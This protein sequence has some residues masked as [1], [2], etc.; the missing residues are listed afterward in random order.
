MKFFISLGNFEKRR[1]T[2]D[3]IEKESESATRHNLGA[4]VVSTCTRTYAYNSQRITRR[5]KA[6]EWSKLHLVVSNLFSLSF[7]T[8]HCV[9]LHRNTNNAHARSRRA[10]TSLKFFVFPP[11]TMITRLFVSREQKLNCIEC[12]REEKRS[13]PIS[14]RAI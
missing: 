14:T 13:I 6:H 4:M 1:D 9:E 10:L 2:R 8:G 3:R 11:P 5:T 7:A 12:A